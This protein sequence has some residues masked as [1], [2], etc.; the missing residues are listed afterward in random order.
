MTPGTVAYQA[1]LYMGFSRQEY[2][3]GSPCPP[4][5]DLP[6]Q[7]SNPD[8]PYCRHILDHLS[9]QGSGDSMDQILIPTRLSVLEE[10]RSKSKSAS[11]TITSLYIAGSQP[12]ASINSVENSYIEGIKW[13]V[14]PM[15]YVFSQQPHHHHGKW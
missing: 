15:V 9:H 11:L 2:W 1:P 12:G 13:T 4:P 8:L 6:N 10:E 14:V 3:S 7:R 5:G